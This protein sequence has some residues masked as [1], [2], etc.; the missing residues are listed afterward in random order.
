[1]SWTQ[2]SNDIKVCKKCGYV[3][4]EFEMYCEGCGD[5]MV[6]IVSDCDFEDECYIDEFEFNNIDLVL[7]SKRSKY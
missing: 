1:M 3:G 2:V 4:G 6:L 5:E 7:E